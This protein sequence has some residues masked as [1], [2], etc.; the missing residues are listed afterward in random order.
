MAL[1]I[2]VRKAFDTLDWNFLFYALEAFGFNQ[3]FCQWIKVLLHSAKLSFVVNGMAAGFFA[4]KRVCEARRSPLP[5]S[6]DW[7][8]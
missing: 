4:C 1:K 5:S 7:Q 3:I 2:D 6:F 8:N